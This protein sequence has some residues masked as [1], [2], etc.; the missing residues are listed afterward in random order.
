MNLENQVC[1]LELSR[2]LKQLG[3]KQD[4]LFY[5]L[6][7]GITSRIEALPLMG[8]DW[9]S[10]FTVAELGEIL[11]TMIVDDKRDIYIQYFKS[12][13]EA[14]ARAKLLIFLIEN[15]LIKKVK[16]LFE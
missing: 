9:Y 11:P 4:S 2:R 7:G 12:E 5:H 13:T 8:E 3:V 1:S 16:D 14:D 10:A 6:I 15:N